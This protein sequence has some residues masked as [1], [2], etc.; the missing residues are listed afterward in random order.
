MRRCADTRMHE[1]VIEQM[2][3]D[4]QMARRLSDV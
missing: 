3:S 2:G 1:I 4:D